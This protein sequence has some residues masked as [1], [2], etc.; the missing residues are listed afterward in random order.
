M[1]KTSKVV[2]FRVD[3][4]MWEWLHTFNNGRI[5]STIYNL[6]RIAMYCMQEKDL[7]AWFYKSESELKGKRLVLVDDDT[8]VCNTDIPRYL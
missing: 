4:R 8:R 1:S 2:S 6:L 5:T 7:R 3:F